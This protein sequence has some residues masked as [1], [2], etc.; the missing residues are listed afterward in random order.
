MAPAIYVAFLFSCSAVL[1]AKLEV[2]VKHDEFLTA[3]QGREPSEEDVHFFLYTRSN[4]IDNPKEI[5]I[6]QGSIESAGFNPSHPTLVFSH[7][8][9]SNGLDF[10]RGFVE[11]FHKVGDYNI[12]TVDWGKLAQ[13][14]DYFGA[15]GRTRFVG[16]HTANLIKIIVDIAGADKLHVIGHSLGAHVSGFIGK[17]YQ[18]LTGKKLPRITGLDPAQPAFD[19]ATK[20]DRLDKE[21]AD[22]VDVIHTNSG[23]IWEGCLSI[24]KQIGHMDFYPAGGKH[25]PDCTD[26]CVV[27]ECSNSNINDL[28]LGGCSH[29]RANIYYMESVLSLVEGKQ[30]LSWLCPTWEDFLAGSCCDSTT[31]VMGAGITRGVEGRYMFNV[32]GESPHALGEDGGAC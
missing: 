29:G 6:D 16:E 7:G 10:A 8:Y 27:G 22:F 21:D 31:A 20:N 28:I 9:T 30:F 32:R 2:G 18:E 4:G 23:M 14:Y 26:I 15:A 12:F 19:F 5:G 24:P 3:G 1:G 11:N 25:Q 17:K 13:W